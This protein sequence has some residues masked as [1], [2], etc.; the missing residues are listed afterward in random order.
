M[1]FT[2]KIAAFVGLIGFAVLRTPESQAQRRGMGLKMDDSKY[3]RLPRRS[4]DILLKSPLPESFDIRALLPEI[5]D[6]GM[7]GTCVGWSAAYYMR[8]A[9]EAARLGI[10]NQ[11]V[12]ISATAF[13]PG[14]LYGQ[15][16]QGQ[17]KGCAEGIFLEDALEVMKTKG[18]AFLSCA[19]GNCDSPY[20]QCDER[21][22]N[23]KIGDYATLFSPKDG[24]ST[25]EQRI[26]AIK[27]ALFEGKNAVLIGMLVPPSFIDEATGHWRAAPGET[28]DNVVGGHSMAV[29]GYDD[30]IN[31][32]SFLIANSWGKTWGS[33]GYTWARYA[34]LARFTRNA[35]Q[36]YS[37]TIPRPPAEA[38]TLK[39]NVDFVLGNEPMAV[40]STVAKGDQVTPTLPTGSAEMITYTMSRPYPSGT[41]FK[42]IVNNTRQ[43]YV[44]ILGSDKENRVSAIF[45]YHSENLVT[46]AVVPANSSVVMPSLYA[47]FTLDEVTGEDYFVVFISQNELNLEELTT[48]V[49]NAAGTIVQKAYAAL[50]EEFISSKEIDY[51]AGK[52]AYEVKGGRKGSV[53]P[54]LVKIVHQ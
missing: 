44:Y 20:E 15:L 37:G 48:K 36:I 43:S 1:R 47:S 53:V 6:Q 33:N 41:R 8:T 4:P 51:Q 28:T 23:Y 25:P 30:H 2:V 35:Y 42:M 19:P 22:A 26:N 54:I 40:R 49:K 3:L 5:G 29:I 7:D 13:S 17:D 12:K 9:M 46:S 11:P 16:K 18:S 38:V 50:G 31:E 14:W 34:D 39:G 27:S 21:A 24:D 45:P 32:G 52:V 10:A